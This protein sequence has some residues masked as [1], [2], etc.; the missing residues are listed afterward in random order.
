MKKSVLQLFLMQEKYFYVCNY[1]S[2]LEKNFSKLLKKDS[3]K[4]LKMF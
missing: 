4:Q 2:L 1:K 3:I